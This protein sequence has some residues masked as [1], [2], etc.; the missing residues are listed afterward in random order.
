MY[1]RKHWQATG[2]RALVAAMA[3]T[4]AAPLLAQDATPADAKVEAPNEPM[5]YDK[6]RR[7][8][9]ASLR[10]HPGTDSQYDYR[11]L[12]AGNADLDG[13]GRPEIIY[14]YTATQTGSA[15]QL[16]EL[17]VMT[18]LAEGDARGQ[19]TSPGKSAYDDETYALI[20][21]S[22]YADDA[23]VHIPGE[24]GTIT[25][26]GDRIRVT[27][28]STRSSKLCVRGKVACPPEGQHAWVYRWSPGKLTR[29][30]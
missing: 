25:M 26:D 21:A 1:E 22:G 7:T 24:M 17:V 30:D 3:L 14:L 12:W 16:N 4:V 9:E 29:A 8:A 19:A 20:R 23:S 10:L 15:M 6:A 28:N 18:P 5:S 11:P 13:D 2:L 27:F